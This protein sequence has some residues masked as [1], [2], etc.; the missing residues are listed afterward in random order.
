MDGKKLKAHE[1]RTQKIKQK[2]RETA[3]QLKTWLKN[4]PDGRRRN[5]HKT[6]RRGT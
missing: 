2:M 1:T 4:K 6:K 3:I 5:K